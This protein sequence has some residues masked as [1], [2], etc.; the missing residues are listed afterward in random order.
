MLVRTFAQLSDHV[1]RISGHP[2]AFGLACVSMLVWLATGP[3]FG[4]SETWQLIVNTSTSV[5]TFLMVFVIQNSQ[6]RDSS[7]L[8]AKLDELIRGTASHQ[9][10]V[11]IETLTQDEIEEIKARREASHA[12]QR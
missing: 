8:Q 3:V 1:A 10:L 9:S 6:N 7:A 4:F 2:I 11:G 5:V 12:S